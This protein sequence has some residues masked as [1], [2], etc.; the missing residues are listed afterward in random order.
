MEH[1]DKQEAIAGRYAFLEDKMA[2]SVFARL[3]Y[4]L[5]SGT[6]I[7]RDHP[8]PASLYRFL[9]KHYNSLQA[10]YA[11]YFEMLLQRQGKNG[12]LII[13]STSRK[14]HGVRCLQ[15]PNIGCI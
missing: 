7:Q 8:K 1:D 15:I 2:R 14:A 11:D 4:V 13:I 5:K 12:I 9:E 3:D 10:Y 6:H